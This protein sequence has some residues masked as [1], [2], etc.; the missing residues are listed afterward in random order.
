M[1]NSKTTLKDRLDPKDVKSLVK[2][3]K[4]LSFSTIFDDTHPY[5]L[6]T[7]NQIELLYQ[8]YAEISGSVTEDGV[9]D[10]EEFQRALGFKES[11]CIRRLFGAFDRMF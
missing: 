6:V 1:G 4:C 2:T 7:A 10:L 5:W 11:D 3:T 8:K 9:I